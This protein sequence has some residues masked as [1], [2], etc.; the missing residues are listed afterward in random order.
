MFKNVPSKFQL[1]ILRF[2]VKLSIYLC[3]ETD[4]SGAVL[5]SG[6]RKETVGR[7]MELCSLWSIWI[8]KVYEE[9]GKL[10]LFDNCFRMYLQSFISENC[11]PF[12]LLSIML[13]PVA[14]AQ[15]FELL[16]SSFSSLLSHLIIH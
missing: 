15:N 4:G 6:I 1:Q 10:F 7:K 3:S 16:F 12:F 2:D 5:K 13:L 11:L 9:E 8:W 14:M